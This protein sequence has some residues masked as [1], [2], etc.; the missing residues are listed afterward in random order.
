[1]RESNVIIEDIK[2]LVLKKWFIYAL[3]M[4][5][6][7]DFLVIAEDIHKIDTYAKVSNNEAMLLLWFLIQ[8]NINCKI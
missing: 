2:K 1:M 4:I 5:L 7:E 8:N 3:C 6:S